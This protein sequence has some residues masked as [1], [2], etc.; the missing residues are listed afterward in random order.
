VTPSELFKRLQDSLRQTHAAA[1]ESAVSL[2]RDFEQ[3]EISGDG[4][5]TYDDGRGAVERFM[6]AGG[7]PTVWVV[8]VRF[9]DDVTGYVEYADSQGQA[10][11]ALPDRDVQAL[12]YKL[13][14]DAKARNER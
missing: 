12:R 14:Q 1:A 9:G 13:R 8:F 6:V 5:Y 7:G 2:L 3:G 4:S 11:V 10:I